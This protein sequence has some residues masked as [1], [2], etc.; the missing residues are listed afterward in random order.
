MWFFAST[1][2]TKAL[3]STSADPVWERQCTPAS[4]SSTVLGPCAAG[5]LRNWL[6]DAHHGVPQIKSAQKPATANKGSI[7][8]SLWLSRSTTRRNRP[9][10]TTRT[11]IAISDR[12]VHLLL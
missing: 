10:A 7:E 11:N 4:S 5:W 2:R 12:K 3:H 1:Q 9:K 8:V 6:R